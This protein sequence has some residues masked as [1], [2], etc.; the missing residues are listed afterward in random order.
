M[1]GGTLR[2]HDAALGFPEK[3]LRGCVTVG[4]M[5]AA[6]SS[7]EWDGCEGRPPIASPNSEFEG[8]RRRPRRRLLNFGIQAKPK[9]NNRQSMI[10]E[11]MEKTHYTSEIANAQSAAY[12]VAGGRL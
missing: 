2:L 7:S 6:L 8:G 5:G 3:P 1:Q 9:L 4:S 10:E 11:N 12:A